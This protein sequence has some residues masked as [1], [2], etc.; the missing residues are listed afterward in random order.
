M[1]TSP[2]TMTVTFGAD[3]DAW[4]WDETRWCNTCGRDVL[5]GMELREGRVWGTCEFCQ[6]RWDFT[7]PD[8]DECVAWCPECAAWRTFV[9]LPDEEIEG[10]PDPDW[11]YWACTICQCS[12]G[13]P[14]AAALVS[15]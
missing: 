8:D 2:D 1:T 9:I 4:E 14:P 12:P 6:E 5:L 13:D 3:E 15:V 11:T 10:D 7:P